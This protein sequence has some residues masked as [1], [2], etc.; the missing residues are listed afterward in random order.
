MVDNVQKPNTF[1][2]SLV[3]VV[4]FISEF[5]VL[6]LLYYFLFSHFWLLNA[7]V[8][9]FFNFFFL[10]WLPN[11]LKC[12][13]VTPWTIC[14]TL[15]PGSTNSCPFSFQCLQYCSDSSLYTCMKKMCEA[16][17]TVHIVSFIGKVKSFA[18]ETVFHYEKSGMFWRFAD[19][20]SQYIYL[21][22]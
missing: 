20:A 13:Y 6:F 19:R 11:G 14:D 16:D 22:I 2:S 9:N 7:C 3:F 10:W 17:L 15:K 18:V 5:K 1:H 21:S 12:P 8:T 4:I